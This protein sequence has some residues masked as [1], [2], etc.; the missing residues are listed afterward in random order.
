MPKVFSTEG[1][2]LSNRYCTST[3]TSE[4]PI[5]W[6]SGGTRL[7]PWAVADHYD[8]IVG[9]LRLPRSRILR[10]RFA[11][12]FCTL[13]RNHLARIF[14]P[15]DRDRS[16]ALRQIQVVIF[17]QSQISETSDARGSSLF[18]IENPT[19]HVDPQCSPILA[20]QAP[21]VLATIVATEDTRIARAPSPTLSDMGLCR[22]R[23][24]RRW[25][26]ERRRPGDN[27]PCARLSN[28]STLI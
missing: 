15:V 23:Y 11:H 5:W 6:L 20:L 27:L 25:R 2:Y 28:S 18:L 16:S 4:L 10:F 26:S 1:R 13:H 17:S 7:R 22:M 14:P 3:G 12:G 24:G 19:P 21:S 9:R 8:T